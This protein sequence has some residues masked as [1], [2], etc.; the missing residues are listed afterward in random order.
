VNLAGA[1]LAA[2]DAAKAIGHLERAVE[3]D[4][5][6][7]QAVQLLSQT[8]RQQG[9]PVKADELVARYRTAMGISTK[10]K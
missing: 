3:L 4:P 2:G 10:R 5:L 9:Q 6:L 8:Y 7:L 1:L